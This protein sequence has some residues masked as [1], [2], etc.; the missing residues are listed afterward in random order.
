MNENGMSLKRAA[1]V[2]EEPSVKLARTASEG[3]EATSTTHTT[4]THVCASGD[5]GP[6]MPVS[7]QNE[8]IEL[9]AKSYP[10]VL[11]TFQREAVICLERNE[12]VLIAAHTSAGKTVVAEYERR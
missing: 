11:D 10:F 2:G 1:D 8:V 6:P 9:N 3:A 7:Y 12:S 5:G 4:C